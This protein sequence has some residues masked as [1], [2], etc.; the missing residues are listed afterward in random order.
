MVEEQKGE[1]LLLGEHVR[2]AVT[3]FRG[4]MSRVTRQALQAG[5]LRQV[6]ANDELRD[7]VLTQAGMISDIALDIRSKIINQTKSPE[8]M[9]GCIFGEID[10]FIKTFEEPTQQ[11]KD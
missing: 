11:L 10:A 2:N 4:Q 9:D 3:T 8:N 7:E 5:V 6:Q 1:S